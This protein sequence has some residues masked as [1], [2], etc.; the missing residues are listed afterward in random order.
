MCESNI[1]QRGPA[2]KLQMLD[3]TVLI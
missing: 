1:S 2:T 3:V